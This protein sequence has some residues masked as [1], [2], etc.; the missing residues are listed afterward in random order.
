MS[1]SYNDWLKPSEQELRIIRGIE[2]LIKSKKPVAVNSALNKLSLDALIRLTELSSIISNYCD[3]AALAPLWCKHLDSFKEG[4]FSMQEHWPLSLPQLVKG[5]YF[6]WLAVDY[7]DKDNVDFGANELEFLFKSA[8]HHCF[9]AYNALIKRSLHSYMKENSEESLTVALSYAQL[10]CD[11]HWTPGYLLLYKCYLVATVQSSIFYENALV[12]LLVARNLSEEPNSLMAQNNAY[13]GKGIIQ[14]NNWQFTSWDK[15]IEDIVS[16]GKI[17][18]SLNIEAYNKSTRVSTKLIE[19][20]Q[21]A[22]AEAERA[23]GE[24]TPGI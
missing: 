9:N 10:A 13:F 16:R 24:Y 1:G 23:P 18:V 14:G 4:G 20:S 15:A 21:N 3:D 2:N 17:A 12:A 8:G 5:Y 19:E 6:S 11:Y 7:R 22:K